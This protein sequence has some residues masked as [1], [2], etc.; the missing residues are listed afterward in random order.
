L[1]WNPEYSLD[2]L[3]QEML[4]HDIEQTSKKKLLQ[5]SGFIIRKSMEE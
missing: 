4:I 1:G 2:D 5:E 3:I